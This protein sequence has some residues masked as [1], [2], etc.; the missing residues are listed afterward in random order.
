MEFEESV[1]QVSDINPRSMFSSSNNAIN[2]CTLEF[3]DWA[4][5][6]IILIEEIPEFPV[7]CLGIASFFDGTLLSFE[8]SFVPLGREGRWQRMLS[9]QIQD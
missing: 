7:T 5:N 6:V 1:S 8:V 9:D 3:N 2:S 4:L